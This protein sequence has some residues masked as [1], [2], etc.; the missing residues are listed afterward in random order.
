MK[1]FATTSQTRT[2][3]F[4][5][6]SLSSLWISEETR[7]QRVIDKARP[8]ADSLRSVN[9]SQL[10]DNT[11]L[12]RRSWK[13]I[14]DDEKSMSLATANVIEAIRRTHGAT[15]YDTQ[16]RAG[17]AM[18]AGNVVEMQT[19]EGK[20]FAGVLPAFVAGLSDRGVHVCAPN[21]YL[22]CRDQQLLA[23]TFAA[24]G[25]TTAV[26]QENDS[27]QATRRAYGADVT[28]GAG[29]LFGFDYLRDQWTRRQAL[30]AP[31][32]SSTVNRLVGRGIETQLRTRG[33]FAVVID[34]ADQVLIDDAT[35]PLLITSADR[36]PAP[37]RSIHDAARNIALTL[38]PDQ[39]FRHVLSNDSIQLTD[40]G[41]R[42]V[43]E[44]EDLATSPLLK[45]PWHAYVDSA[46]KAEYLLRRDR[47]YVVIDDS[48]QLVEPSTGRLFSDRIWSD[49]LHQAVQ[50]KERLPVTAETESQGRVT[51]QSFFRLYEHLSGMTGTAESCRAEFRSIYRLDT[52][53]I[54]PRLP[55]RRCV[56]PTGVFMNERDKLQGLIDETRQMLAAGRSVLVGTNHIEQTNVIAT[57]L[58]KHGIC[59]QVLSGVQSEQE[60]NIIA[61][62]GQAR[63]VTVATHLA[64]RGTDI[65]LHRSVA[66]AGGLHVIG[67]EHHRL[68]RVDR[69]LI[70]RGA[71]QGDPGSARFYVSPDD[72]FISRHA[73]YLAAA[74]VRCLDSPEKLPAFC[75]SIRSAQRRLESEDRAIRYRLMKRNQRPGK[76]LSR[77][78]MG[79]GFG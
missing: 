45:R 19:G 12:L 31:L 58:E 7:R 75:R 54:Q 79:I 57:A 63:M 21:S 56:L 18:C 29:Q 44:D 37:D 28:Y 32:G 27:F 5:Q 35:S 9:A 67:W 78:S 30:A 2:F 39:D 6:L 51:R 49:G 33:R 14:R 77:R 23:P 11:N 20:T 47:N 41:F 40:S 36:C 16:I 46:L 25:M 48:L 10:H 43:Y 26:R 1:P 22:A 50:T 53:E 34:E 15:L 72:L 71:R 24:L 52:L 68:H 69:Q 59:P 66:L 13:T 4:P 55:S 17:L 3:A 42:R 38:T 70:G 65:V 74:L 76:A 60:A 62:A 61:Q 8:M 64:G 73:P